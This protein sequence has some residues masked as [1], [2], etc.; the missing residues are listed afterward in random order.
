MASF[1]GLRRV[2][3]LGL[4]LLAGQSAVAL[5]LQRGPYLQRSAPTEI[6]IRWRTDVAAD[7]RVQYGTN[8]NSLSLTATNSG[9][10]TNHEV[11]LTN[12]AANTTYYYSAGS[13]ATNLASGSAYFFVTAPVA[14]M[15]TRIW[16]IGDSGTGD[17]SAAEMRDGYTNYAAARRTD[18]WLMLGDNAYFGGRDPQYQVAVF[19]MFRDLLRQTAVWPCIG[20]DE[21]QFDFEQ[22]FTLP[23]QGEAG[24][25]SSSNEMY[26]AFNHGNIHFVALNSPFAEPST[27]GRMYQWLKQ[28]LSANTNQWLIAYW[29]HPPYSRG[30]H[31]SDTDP[32]QIAMRTNFVR[33]LEQ[34]GV[35]LVLCGHSHD[36]ERSFLLHG[37]YG[38]STNLLPEMILNH[39]NGREDQEGAYRKLLYGTN[40][41]KGAVYV[42]AGA[43]SRPL[44]IGTLDHPAMYISFAELG[45]VVLDVDGNR[46][47]ARYLRSDG[48]IRDYF[49]IIKEAAPTLRITLSESK[50]LLSW[51]AT[52]SNFMA[53]V[54]S[55]LNSSI[56]WRDITNDATLSQGERTVRLARSGTNQFYRLHRPP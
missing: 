31:N 25:F 16:A 22:V 40:A 53:Q 37:H 35:D 18:V 46:L 7:S 32:T 24:G 4:F 56:L 29:H 27:N 23:G 54:T 17:S 43:S 39:G 51:P 55:D 38:Y 48:V 3:A 47:D 13:S 28:D 1:I 45:S 41:N 42:V 26:Y 30:S 44:P 21:D 19:D 8:V 15:P 11:R 9:A 33:L 36:Y 50:V 5:Q 10:F 49:T 34:H 2:C 12:L 52:A 6:T 20:N 14:A